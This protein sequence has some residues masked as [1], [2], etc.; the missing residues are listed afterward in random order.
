MWWNGQVKVA[1]KRKE[2][3]WKEMLR[4][5]D[6]DAKERYLEAYKEGEKK[7]KKCFGYLL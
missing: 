7:V 2:D 3:A 6:E 1:V 4:V 5:K